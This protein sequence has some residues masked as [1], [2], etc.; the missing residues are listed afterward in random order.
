MKSF[1]SLLNP[2]PIYDLRKDLGFNSEL[3]DIVLIFLLPVHEIQISDAK[4]PIQIPTGPITRTRSKKM[5]EDLRAYIPH[6]N[7][8]KKKS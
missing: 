1:I 6:Y 3:H 7:Y 2:Q 5:K 4:E 8:M